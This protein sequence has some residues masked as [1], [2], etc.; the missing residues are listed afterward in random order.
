MVAKT[1]LLPVV[2]A[3][4]PL[5]G[6]PPAPTVTVY[7]ADELGEN[8]DSDEAPPPDVSPIFATL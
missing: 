5:T 4:F 2:P 3:T 1:E 7:E 6:A 8:K